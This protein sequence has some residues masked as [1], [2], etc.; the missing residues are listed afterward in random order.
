MFIFT[1]VVLTLSLFFASSSF[2]A[3]KVKIAISELINETASFYID[4]LRIAYKSIGVE[5]IFSIYPEPR[6]I[7]L[8]ESGEVD[9]IGTRLESYEK[10]NPNSIKINVPIVDAIP[11]KT[12]VLKKDLG[13]V[14]KLEKPFVLSSISCIGCVEYSKAFK[15][16]INAYVPTLLLAMKMLEMKRADLIITTSLYMS[17]APD[18]EKFTVFNDSIYTTKVFHF[19]NKKKSHLQEKLTKQ[20]LKAKKRGAFDVNQLNYKK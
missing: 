1:K 4:E 16:P 7:Y 6:A 13:R 14:S 18:R 17:K 15:L 9:A 19:I 11:F 8:F 12:F 3:E 20:I 2:A 10:I 5:P